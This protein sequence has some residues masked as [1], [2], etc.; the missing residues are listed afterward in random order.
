MR[1]LQVRCKTGDGF[2]RSAVAS[3]GGDGGEEQLGL[4]SASIEVGCDGLSRLLRGL[5]GIEEND[6][7]RTCSAER[8]A[9]HTFFS[10]YFLEA[11]KQRAEWG[12]IG[13]VDAIVKRGRE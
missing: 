1:R 4:E 10:C 12:A 9:E 8:D 3:A 13:L 5:A 6:D 7:R 11:W 2:L